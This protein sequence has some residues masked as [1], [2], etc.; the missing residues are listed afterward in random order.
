MRNRTRSVLPGFMPHDRRSVTPRRMK[1]LFA[2]LALFAILS[3][4]LLPLDA[5]FQKPQVP[6]CCLPGGKHHCNQKP[7]GTGFQA[8]GE[9]CPYASQF[10]AA[11][12]TGV[13]LAHSQVAGLE[14]V[15]FLVVAVVSAGQRSVCRQRS[16][17]GPPTHPPK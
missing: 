16:D 17:R 11:G 15:G 14:F 10:V 2:N 13:G 5:S 8:K 9:R 4:F 7:A 1:W 12:F 6:A 3:T